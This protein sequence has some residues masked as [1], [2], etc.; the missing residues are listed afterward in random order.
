MTVAL[1]NIAQMLSYALIGGLCAFAW[2][3]LMFPFL[4]PEITTSVAANLA[5]GILAVVGAVLALVFLKSP[6][7]IPVFL[8]FLGFIFINKFFEGMFIIIDKLI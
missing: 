7:R 6:K 2:G 8:F 3:F 4:S 1:R 5:P